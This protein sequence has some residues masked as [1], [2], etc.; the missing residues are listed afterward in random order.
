MLV[1]RN[2]VKTRRWNLEAYGSNFSTPK[3]RASSIVSLETSSNFP[4]RFTLSSPTCS[5][6]LDRLYLT[7]GWV[8]SDIGR[9]SYDGIEVARLARWEV[10]QA[11][12]K[13]SLFKHHPPQNRDRKRIQKNG[14]ERRR[15][16]RTEKS[17]LLN[18]AMLFH[19]ALEI[20]IS[21]MHLKP[22]FPWFFGSEH[23][24]VQLWDIIWP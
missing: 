5:F 8:D 7:S 24:Y 20:Q 21:S 23:M 15:R 2:L 14:L 9:M 22:I 17:Q 1:V 4:E 10:L 3:V 6:F 18:L 11:P 19:Q 12:S 13:Y 16:C